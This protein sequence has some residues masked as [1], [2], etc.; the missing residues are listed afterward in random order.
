MR[1]HTDTIQQMRARTSTKTTT[2]TTTTVTETPMTKY[3][4]AIQYIQWPRKFCWKQIDIGCLCICFEM[5]CISVYV[6]MIVAILSFGIE[7]RFCLRK[8][9]QREREKGSGLTMK[10][11]EWAFKKCHTLFQSLVL[12]LFVS[13]SLPLSLAL[14]LCHAQFTFTV[15]NQWKQYLQW[16]DNSIEYVM[17]V[18]FVMVNV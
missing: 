16:N 18:I 4:T 5:Y 3:R 8:Y 9:S 15:S 13:L 10:L 1:W 2:S 17:R 11:N 7:N 14:Y 12:F 6:A